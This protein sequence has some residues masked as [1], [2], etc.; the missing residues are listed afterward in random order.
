MMEKLKST[1]TTPQSHPYHKFDYTTPWF[2]FLSYQECCYSLGVPCSLGKFLR[3][4]RYLKE[5]NVK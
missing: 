4:H 1:L 2:E 5:V 3:Y